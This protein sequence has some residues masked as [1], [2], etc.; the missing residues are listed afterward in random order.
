MAVLALG[1]VAGEGE[2][3]TWGEVLARVGSGYGRIGGRGRVCGRLG[4]GRAPFQP[5]PP[6]SFPR[7]LLGGWAAYR[8]ASAGR[9]VSHAGLG[10]MLMLLMLLVLMLMLLMLMLLHG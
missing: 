5:P 8:R 10:L 1:A 2:G 4:P 6:P 9:A 7:A 3:G